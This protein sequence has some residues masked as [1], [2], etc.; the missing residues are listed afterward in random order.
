MA[1]KVHKSTSPGRRDSVST[2][3]SDITKNKPEKSL[4]APLLKKGG[5]NNRGRIT[6]RHRGGGHKRR[7]RIIDFDRRKNGQAE[8][9]SI[10]YDPNRT[11]RISLIRYEDGKKNYIVAPN[12]LKVGQK[13]LNDS[14]ENYQIGNAMYLSDI[15]TG[16]LVHNIEINPG[17]GGQLVKSCLL[18]TSPS[19]R[20]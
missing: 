5:R 11:A 10:E 9:L 16:T 2:D 3:F 13:I 14:S 8:V 12:N 1:L 4:L 15:P 17:K 20:D 7:Y 19:P 18:Y 6:V